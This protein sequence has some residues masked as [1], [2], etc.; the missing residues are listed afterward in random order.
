MPE[1]VSDSTEIETYLTRMFKLI[2]QQRELIDRQSELIAKALRAEP[3]TP[4]K[5]EEVRQP[6]SDKGESE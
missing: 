4:V 5:K 6:N 2:K 1:Y 3:C